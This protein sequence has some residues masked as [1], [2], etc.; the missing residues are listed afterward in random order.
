[1]PHEDLAHRLISRYLDLTMA[2][3]LAAGDGGAPA[4]NMVLR[5]DPDVARRRAGSTEAGRR[6]VPDAARAAVAAL[7]TARCRDRRFRRLLD[8]SLARHQRLLDQL[9]GEEA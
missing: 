1:M 8:D 2:E 4:K 9:R 7:L 5:L 6:A 3:N